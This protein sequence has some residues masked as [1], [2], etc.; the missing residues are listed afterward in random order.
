MSP[1]WQVSLEVEL[2]GPFGPEQMRGRRQERL[3]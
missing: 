2:R 3:P 1:T